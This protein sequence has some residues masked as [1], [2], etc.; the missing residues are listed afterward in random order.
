MARQGHT[1]PILKT[2]MPGHEQVC[3][4]KRDGF[5]ILRQ[6]FRS[7]VPVI[8]AVLPTLRPAL[9]KLEFHPAKHQH[10]HDA[11]LVEDYRLGV[12]GL[13]VDGIRRQ[14]ES[15]SASLSGHLWVFRRQVPRRRKSTMPAPRTPPSFT[16]PSRRSWA[17]NG[18]LFFG[19]M[20]RKNRLGPGRHGVTDQLPRG[21]MILAPKK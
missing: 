21:L 8:W 16:R 20:S 17:S 4:F 6:A 5:V 9:V 7:V 11:R 14:L 15:V 3:N 13:S 10:A 18:G 1:L 19:G 2:P 12:N